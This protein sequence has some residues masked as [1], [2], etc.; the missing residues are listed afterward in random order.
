MFAAA[1]EKGKVPAHYFKLPVNLYIEWS[2]AARAGR[3]HQRTGE[4][5]D[6][7]PDVSKALTLSNEFRLVLLWP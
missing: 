7:E 2:W 4:T 5:L 1:S 6:P 3:G